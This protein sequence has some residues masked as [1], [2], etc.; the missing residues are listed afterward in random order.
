[1]HKG[2][3]WKGL[4]TPDTDKID[5]V[6]KSAGVRTFELGRSLLAVYHNPSPAAHWLPTI[7]LF[8]QAFLLPLAA[9]PRVYAS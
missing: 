5:R 1:M 7:W 4:N 2:S 8:R 3:L 9:F 6:T